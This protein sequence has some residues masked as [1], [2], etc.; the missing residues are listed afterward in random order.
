LKIYRRRLKKTPVQQIT[1]YSDYSH[2]FQGNA[3]SIASQSE[4]TQG[5]CICIL[6]KSEGTISRAANRG[7][8]FSTRS[9][10]HELASADTFQLPN[11]KANLQ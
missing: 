2:D 5:V 4:E 11:N 9:K 1:G 7:E 6:Q 8:T 3:D 10:Y